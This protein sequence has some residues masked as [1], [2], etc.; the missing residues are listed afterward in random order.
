[1]SEISARPRVLSGMQPSGDSLHLGNYLGALVNWVKNQDDYE[2]LFFIHLA[3]LNPTLMD[4]V[5]P[6]VFGDEP[7]IPFLQLIQWESAFDQR[8]IRL[9]SMIFADEKIDILGDTVGVNQSFRFF[10]ER[11]R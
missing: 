8:L 4:D 7:F 11:V 3:E 10:F 5:A 2:T 6:A 1:M 9:R